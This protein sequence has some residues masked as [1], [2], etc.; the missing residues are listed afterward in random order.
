MI[1]TKKN[2]IHRGLILINTFLFTPSNSNV[3]LRYLHERD[4][5]IHVI[6]WQVND[7]IY[8]C[9]GSIYMCGISQFAFVMVKVDEFTSRDILWDIFHLIQLF[10]NSTAG[11]EKQ[12]ALSRQNR[13]VAEI[14]QS[15]CQKSKGWS[16][17]LQII[18]P[19]WVPGD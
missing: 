10:K 4:K 6:L 16:C 19:T 12:D 18:I 11:S 15:V 9:S 3:T 1:V 7:E 13:T 8:F 5:I 14:L 17:K 2:L